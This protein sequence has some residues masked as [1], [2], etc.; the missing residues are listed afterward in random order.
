MNKLM[1]PKILLSVKK[2]DEIYKIIN[3]ADIIDLKNPNDGPIGSW[4]K[5]EIKEV[6]DLY[7]KTF[8]IS[9]TLGNLKT[10]AEVNNK[11]SIFDSLGLKYIKIGYFYD[12]IENL[13]KILEFLK[14]KDLSTNIVI[15]FFAEK[16][17]VIEKLSDHLEIFHKYKFN[18]IMIDTF[19]KSSGN[20][21]D[22]INLET[23]KKILFESDR[24]KINLGLAGKLKAKNF[25]QLF[26]LQPNIIGFRGAVCKT[27]DRN[28][29]I[30]IKKVKILF[31]QL[32]FE[33]KQA[34]ATA[35]AC[36]DA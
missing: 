36:I 26:S 35:G 13:G 17:K 18:H 28:S 29:K 10:M 31:Q 25:K 22:K 1:R 15:V 3:Y 34:Q 9:A 33:I 2:I 4:N 5:N 23:L 20:L 32:N 12:S 6:I 21:F 8:S 11:V 24:L 16:Q 14:K 19:D 7:Q 30:C 27:K